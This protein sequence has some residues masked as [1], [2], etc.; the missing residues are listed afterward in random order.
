MQYY[1]SLTKQGMQCFAYSWHWHGLGWLSTYHCRF[2]RNCAISI[3]IR[4][5]WLKRGRPGFI[6]LWTAIEGIQL[7]PD[8]FKL[9]SKRVQYH[10]VTHFW[11]ISDRGA[12]R[13][14]ADRR[15]KLHVSVVRLVCR[16]FSPNLKYD[17]SSQKKMLSGSPSLDLE[18]SYIFSNRLTRNC[19][20]S[21]NHIQ[22][23]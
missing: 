17:V 15:T 12:F 21:S 2:N 18:W 13:A 19:L 4:V 5:C 9:S 3:H 14:I 1:A 6:L 7:E 23:L 11:Q 20:I 8:E 10:C 22:Y 16:V